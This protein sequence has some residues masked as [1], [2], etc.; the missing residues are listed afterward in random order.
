VGGQCHVT[1][2]LPTGNSPGTQHMGDYV[3]LR[4]CLDVYG[5]ETPHWVWNSRL[6]SLQQVIAL[7]KPPKICTEFSLYLLHRYRNEE[8]FILCYSITLYQLLKLLSIECLK[9]TS[10]EGCSRNKTP[11]VGTILGFI[12]SDIRNK[13]A[14]IKHGTVHHK[15]GKQKENEEEKQEKTKIKEQMGKQY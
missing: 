14:R 11:I 10:Q 2:I 4:A 3:G 8:D 15:H 6:S 7:T 5:E 13:V 9:M 1:A 12:S